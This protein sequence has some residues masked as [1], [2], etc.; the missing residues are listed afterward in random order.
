MSLV[1]MD[2]SGEGDDASSRPPSRDR[3]AGMTRDGGLRRA[4]FR[5]RKLRALDARARGWSEAAAQDDGDVDGSAG[6]PL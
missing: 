3:H 1:E 6:A 4:E 5:I 2:P